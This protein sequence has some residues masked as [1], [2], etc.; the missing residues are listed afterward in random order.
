MIALLTVSRNIFDNQGID[1]SKHICHLHETKRGIGSA[2]VLAALMAGINHF[3][4]TLGG[5]G[6][7]PSNWMDDRLVRGTGDY[8]YKDPDPRYVGLICIEDILVQ[9]DE[10]GLKHTYNID[11]ILKLGKQIERT[12]GRR[13]RSDVIRNL[14]TPHKIGKNIPL[15]EKIY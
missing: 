10:M 15:K 7:Q 9:M 2:N 3:E 8:Y 13:L 1:P 6:G 14:R 11:H 4:A 5:I 12:L